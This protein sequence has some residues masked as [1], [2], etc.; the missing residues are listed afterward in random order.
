M[1]LLLAAVVL[2]ALAP[3]AGH[4]GQVEEALAA[5]FPGV[6]AENVRPT[7]IPGIWEIAVGGQVVYLSED[8]QYM[9]RGDVVDLSTGRSIAEAR[10]AELRLEISKQ[11]DEQRMIVFSPEKPKHTVTIFTDIDC[12]YCRKLHREMA[13]LNKLGI[14]VRYAFYPRAG[15]GSD[16]WAKADAVWCAPNR[17]DALTRAKLGEHVAAAKACSDTPVAEQY[18]LGNEIGIRGTPAIMTEEGELLPGYV[19]ADQLAAWLDG[20]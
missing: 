15:P 5:K 2:L 18:R 7:P 6:E 20:N 8:G 19:P 14:K 17:N 12:G 10:Q 16:S 1:P 9:L 3:A 4:A 11:F 13:E